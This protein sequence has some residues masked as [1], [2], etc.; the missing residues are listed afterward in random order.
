LETKSLSG[1]ERLKAMEDHT[2]GFKLAEIDMQL[3]GTGEIMGY[4]QS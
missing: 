3:R 4:R 2:D 1:N